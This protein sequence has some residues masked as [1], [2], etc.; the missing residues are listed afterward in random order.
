M[1]DKRS[2]GNLNVPNVITSLRILGSAALL[3]IE[4]FSAVFYIVYTFSGFSDVLDGFIAR[5]AGLTSQL[6]ARLDSIADLIFYAVMVL[7]VFPRLWATLPGWIWI[8]TLSVVA[9][10]AIAYITAA[11]KF[12][13]F[14]SM[15]TYMNKATGAAVFCVPYFLL[16]PCAVELCFLAC[17]IAAVSSLEELLMHLFSKE[18]N[19]GIKTIIAMKNR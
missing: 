1:S 8:M 11:I 12:K 15:H 10:R 5:R 2:S 9:V 4:P 16:L 7:R 3:F 18:Y 19:E 14:S 17:C 6:G 13:R